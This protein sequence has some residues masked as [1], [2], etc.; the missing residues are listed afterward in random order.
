MSVSGPDNCSAKCLIIFV[1]GSKGPGDLLILISFSFCAI[2]SLE[3]VGRSGS[4]PP[5]CRSFDILL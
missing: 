3:M 5:S 1:G 4:S 2:H